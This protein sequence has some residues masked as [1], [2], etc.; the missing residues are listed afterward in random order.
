MNA[1]LG[2]PPVPSTTNKK[3]GS[4]AKS[5]PD[6][7]PEEYMSPLKAST[8]NNPIGTTTVTG[9]DQI[10]MITP[11]QNQIPMDSSNVNV[12]LV[13]ISPRIIT[14]NN[15]SNPRPAAASLRKRGRLSLVSSNSPKPKQQQQL[16]PIIVSDDDEL[17]GQNSMNNTRNRRT[18]RTPPYL[19]SIVQ[20]RTPLASNTFNQPGQFQHQPILPMHHQKQQQQEQQHQHLHDQLKNPNYMQQYEAQG[21]GHEDMPIMGMSDHQEVPIPSTEISESPNVS[22]SSSSSITTQTITSTNVTVTP[23]PQKRRRRMTRSQM[24]LQE[25]MET[26][27]RMEI[28]Q[29]QQQQQQLPLFPPMNEGVEGLPEVP[30]LQKVESFISEEE[31]ARQVEA[32]E[33]ACEEKHGDGDG[34]KE[35][36]NEVDIEEQRRIEAEIAAKNQQ[37]Q[38][39]E[40]ERRQQLLRQEQLKRQQELEEAQRSQQQPIY[41]QLQ[42]G[43]EQ[44]QQEEQEQ[45]QQEYPLTPKPEDHLRNVETPQQ[46]A[47]ASPDQVET[48]ICTNESNSSSSVMM[49][50]KDKYNPQASPLQVSPSGFQSRSPKHRSPLVINAAINEHDDDDDD[51]VN[52]RIQTSD[53]TNEYE[54]IMETENENDNEN[55]TQQFDDNDSIIYSDG[56]R[57]IDNDNNINSQ[58]SEEDMEIGISQQDVLSKGGI[59]KEEFE[60]NSLEEEEDDDKLIT[61]MKEEMK[62]EDVEEEMKE[63]MKEEDHEDDGYVHIPND[64]PSVNVSAVSTPINMFR[65]SQQSTNPLES[66]SNIDKLSTETAFGEG[67]IPPNT[68]I[69]DQKTEEQANPGLKVE[70]DEKLEIKDED[71]NENVYEEKM[72][73][74]EEKEE[75]K[76]EREEIQQRTQFIPSQESSP[77]TFRILSLHAREVELVNTKCLVQSDKFIPILFDEAPLLPL[78]C[79]CPHNKLCPKAVQK[80]KLKR[81][82]AECYEALMECSNNFPR[83]EYWFQMSSDDYFCDDCVQELSSVEDLQKQILE[84][85]E[86]VASNLKAYGTKKVHEG[87]IISKSWLKEWRSNLLAQR[88][89]LNPPPTKGVASYF[90]TTTRNDKIEYFKTRNMTDDILCPHGNLTVENKLW[91][92]LPA[93][94]HESLSHHYNPGLEFCQYNGQQPP[95]CEE[96]NM[97]NQALLN[98]QQRQ[99]EAVNNELTPGLRAL[100][101]RKQWFPKSGPNGHYT[102]R[103]GYYCIISHNFLQRWRMK[104]ESPS[105]VQ[106]PPTGIDNSIFICEHGKCKLPLPVADYLYAHMSLPDRPITNFTNQTSE[107]GELQCEIITLQDWNDLARYHTGDKSYMIQISIKSDENVDAA[108]NRAMREIGAPKLVVGLMPVYCPD[109]HESMTNL[110]NIQKH[111]YV[112]QPITVELVKPTS[113]ISAQ[114]ISFN[115]GQ[116]MPNG[117][118]TTASGRPRR[119]TR[120]GNRRKKVTI[121]CSHDDLGSFVKL[122]VFER[123]ELPSMSFSIFCKGVELGD[124]KTLAS[125]DV[126]IDDTLY[127]DLKYGGDVDLNFEDYLVDNA[128]RGIVEDDNAGFGGTLLS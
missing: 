62:E 106:L 36:F 1:N 20:Q 5:D 119:S 3:A 116:V 24:K 30:Q 85:D 19:P 23:S 83:E 70:I 58:E 49:K 113:T 7:I 117:T 42:H 18:T 10:N 31:L 60:N 43:E 37:S 4:K 33:K 17:K 81:I 44:Q 77:K 80:Y 47:F 64:I 97:V 59:P 82:P 8:N 126:T 48:P 38:F 111:N 73:Q 26:R 34:D 102:L 13:D 57:I 76:D 92:V 101:K 89:L 108:A 11:P 98:E 50:K 74:E 96:C 32:I 75:Q 105:D 69:I 6:F 104:M 93:D 54:E 14:K 110:L 84:N 12:N 39:E 68:S 65:I 79:R 121:Y 91:R 109:C 90:D 71:D 41:E 99:V 115:N 124:M 52:R 61:E 15:N 63:D 107:Y 46:L 122:K 45:Q 78:Q 53:D 86:L 16:S 120:G 125:Q 35:V 114:E 103:E 9:A 100:L 21:A 27:Q 55:D 94:I 87:I 25:E 2:I 22:S 72:K 95:L 118:T 112:N 66:E 67:T 88:R 40:Q 51:K 56:D 28:Q 123:A 29:Q 128:G 127:V